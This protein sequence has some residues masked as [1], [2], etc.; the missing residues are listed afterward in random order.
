MDDDFSIPVS[1]PLDTDGF[2]RRECPT[3]VSQFK[4]FSQNEDDV[5]AEP[6]DQYFCPLCG[7]PADTGNWWT[8]DQLEHVRAVAAPEVV[9]LLKNGVGDAFRDIAGMTVE[10]TRGSGPDVPSPDSLFETD[11]MVIVE[12]HC[13]PNEPVKVPED[14]TGRVHCLVCGSTYSA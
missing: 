9:R 12:S 6:V 4:W 3:C 2:L 13:H 8:P 1:I 14:R 5:Q 11:D 10:Q 7:V